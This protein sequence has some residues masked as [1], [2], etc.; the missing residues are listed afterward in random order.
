MCIQM[1]L[2]NFSLKDYLKRYNGNNNIL[3]FEQILNGVEYI[4]ANKII[5]RDLKPDNIF[6]KKL[7]DK[8]IVKIGDFGLATCESNSPSLT[9]CESNYKGK[10]T[11][12]IGTETYAAPEQYYNSIATT[13]SD[14]YSLGIIL[15]ELIYPF[16]TNM[17]R[18][19]TIAN[20]K[21]KN[22][23]P[24]DILKY[25]DISRLI[26][27]MTSIDPLNRPDIYT[28]KR[29]LY[30]IIINKFPTMNKSSI[31][32]NQLLIINKI[33]ENK[34]TALMIVE[35][36]INSIIKTVSLYSEINKINM[37]ML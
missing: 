29:L 19:T 26:K 8:F 27:L 2:C 34:S 25:P 31:I 20:L 13:Y 10:I 14:I 32:N 15:L 6:I 24:N 23:L 3:I 36:I 28:I 30:S 22:E 5:H 18:Y 9:T 21:E 37:S 4:H 11:K 16:K 1:E 7:P 12:Y 17:G 33:P 35:N